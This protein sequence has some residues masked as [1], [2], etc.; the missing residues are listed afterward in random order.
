MLED[1]SANDRVGRE[2]GAAPSTVATTTA[3]AADPDAPPQPQLVQAQSSR[4]GG[5]LRECGRTEWRSH[6]GCSA[7]STGGTTVAATSRLS[8]FATAAINSADDAAARAGGSAM[9]MACSSTH[10][11]LAV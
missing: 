3:A 9:T 7:A 1:V 4:G 10:K 2:P 8:L 6:H 11:H 5:R